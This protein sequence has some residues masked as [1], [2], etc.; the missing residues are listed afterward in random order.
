MGNT[1]DREGAS[2]FK[3]W[4]AHFRTVVRATRLGRRPTEA[5]RVRRLAAGRFCHTLRV[6]SQPASP[7]ETTDERRGATVAQQRTDKQMTMFEEAP[8]VDA[9]AGRPE[10]ESGT[11]I[12]S[13]DLFAGAGGLEPRLPPCGPGITCRSSRSSTSLRRP[14]VRAELRVRGVR[15]RHRGR[16]ELPRGRPDHR[17]PAVPGIQPA[18]P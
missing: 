7:A 1:N 13:I 18:R 12:T 10:D 15:R 6:R 17:R 2:R 9:R 5:V 4:P 3:P 16:P 14:D 11:T 8:P